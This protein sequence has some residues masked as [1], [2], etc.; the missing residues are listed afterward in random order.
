MY[1]NVQYLT[2]FYVAVNLAFSI[3]RPTLGK[4][5]KEKRQNYKE[6]PSSSVRMLYIVDKMADIATLQ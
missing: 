1:L 6:P 3:S 2:L 5:K 4:K